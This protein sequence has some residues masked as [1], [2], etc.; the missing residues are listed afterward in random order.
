MKVLSGG[1]NKK[2][3]WKLGHSGFPCQVD[4]SVFMIRPERVNFFGLE[5][6]FDV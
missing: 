1:V 6:M 5:F 4:M 3:K 2:H